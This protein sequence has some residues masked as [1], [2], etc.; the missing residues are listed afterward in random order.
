MELKEYQKN[1]IDTF[2]L[3]VTKLDEAKSAL[4]NFP[5]QDIPSYVKNYPKNAWNEMGKSDD[6]YFD[7][8]SKAS[9]E[10]YYI[11]NICYKIPTGG[12]KTLLGIHTIKE[13][14]ITNG[15]VLWLVPT[16]A[17]YEQT[18]TAFRNRDHDYRIELDHISSNHTKILEKDDLFTLNDHNNNL[19][20]MIVIIASTNRNNGGKKYTD[21][22]FLKINRDGSGHNS[23]FPEDDDYVGIDNLPCNLKKKSEHIKHSLQNVIKIIK[24]IIILDESHKIATKLKDEEYKDLLNSYNPQLV[25]ELSATPKNDVSNILVDVK[26]TDLHKENMIKLPIKLDVSE[27]STW[28]NTL[29]SAITTLDSL[30]R[31][32]DKL[33]EYIRPICVISVERTDPDK[34]DSGFIHAHHVRDYLIT[35]GIP[36][37]AIC[38]KSAHEDQLGR[39]NLMLESSN[40]RYIITKSALKEGWDCSFAYVLVILDNTQSFTSSTQLLGRVMRQPRATKTSIESLNS[41]YVFCFNK[42]SH[43][44]LKTIKTGLEYGGL[45][46]M[47]HSIKDNDIRLTKDCTK[48]PRRD[49]LPTTIPLPQVLHVD[50]KH[51]RKLDYEYDILSEIN[52]SDICVPNLD[53]SNIDE[54][55]HHTYDLDETGNI[56]NH[57]TEVLYVNR[58]I[59][60]M[61]FTHAIL[62]LIPNPWNAYSIVVECIDILSK[63][64]SN[65]EIMSNRIKI[66]YL[67]YNE[68]KKI[69]D[70]KAKKIF[71]Q[72]LNT[73]KIQFKLQSDVINLENGIL[74]LKGCTP[75]THDD[76]Q[77][78]QKNLF[79]E[80]YID[81]FNEPEKNFALYLDKHELIQWWY[82]IAVN[83]NNMDYKLAGWMKNYIHPDFIAYRKKSRKGEVFIIE[84]K[85]THL[86]GN[87][88]T[89]YKKMLL[90]KLNDAYKKSNDMGKLEINELTLTMLS[91]EN[92]PEE[93]SKLINSETHPKES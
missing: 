93:F 9:K 1:V 12:G 60:L 52:F 41:C 56:E 40:I 73:K 66:K 4:N 11:P 85:G 25:L 30:Q 47:I 75:L 53:M 31:D 24:P 78:I 28:E 83:Q 6:M 84:T 46:D 89:E 32:A 26:G 45:G 69:V 14:G 54:S 70:G 90:E 48:T 42:T 64:M 57:T 3:W 27:E 35:Y 8:K 37:D 29:I 92:W 88:D 15:F 58:N 86:L 21:E 17:I 51:L 7:R 10:G 55:H 43:D 81:E 67:L 5:E 76:G 91:G 39:K 23:F 72:K 82:R 50:G 22:D 79:N 18:I 71:E 19:C 63:K 38:I 2:R 77:S 49:G 44:T 20:I 59:D 80:V 65:V 61:F 33:D 36:E 13:W 74:A 62:D 68:I 34:I 87:E 16:K